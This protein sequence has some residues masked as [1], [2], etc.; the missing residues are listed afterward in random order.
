MMVQCQQQSILK[1]RDRIPG[2]GP[3][4]NRVQYHPLYN[5]SECVLLACGY[6][7]PIPWLPKKEQQAVLRNVP[8]LTRKSHAEL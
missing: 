4:E 6:T 1:I 3:Q 5:G 7:I 8:K 2:H